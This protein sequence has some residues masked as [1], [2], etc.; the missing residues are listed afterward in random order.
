M[1]RKKQKAISRQFTSADLPRT[2]TP[3]PAGQTKLSEQFLPEKRC[4]T[5]LSKALIASLSEKGRLKT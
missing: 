1:V 5:R 4:R 3:I 2:Q